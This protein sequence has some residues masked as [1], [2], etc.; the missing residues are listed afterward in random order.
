[1][2]AHTSFDG[3]NPKKIPPIYLPRSSW[4]KYEPSGRFVNLKSSICFRSETII[5]LI[6]LRWMDG[7]SRLSNPSRRKKK[8]GGRIINTYTKS[9][10]VSISTIERKN[11]CCD[12]FIEP[13]IYTWRPCMSDEWCKQHLSCNRIKWFQRFRPYK[14]PQ[15][16]IAIDHRC[17]RIHR[18]GHRRYS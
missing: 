12:G 6:S 9:L 18:V 4:I 14:C 10:G 2:I 13:S 8:I 16:E 5:C 1:M 15:S 17:Y 11:W 3:F 7:Q